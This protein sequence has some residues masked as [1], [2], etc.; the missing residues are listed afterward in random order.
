MVLEHIYQD[1]VS[2]LP[3][4]KKFKEKWSSSQDDINVNKQVTIY[5]K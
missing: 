1:H 2:I 3:L 4:D 5:E